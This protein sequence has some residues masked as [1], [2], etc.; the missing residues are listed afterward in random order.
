MDL[1]NKVPAERSLLTSHLQSEILQTRN[2]TDKSFFFVFFTTLR[3]PV[4][5]TPINLIQHTLMVYTINYL[6][7]WIGAKYRCN[8]SLES[9]TEKKISLAGF[10]FFCHVDFKIIICFC[11]CVCG[12]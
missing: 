12:S 6:V 10:A 3:F 2:S 4:N 5:Q 1:T 8:F 9:L 11:C 7:M